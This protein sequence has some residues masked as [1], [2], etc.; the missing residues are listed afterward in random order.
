V[1]AIPD[2]FHSVTPYLPVRGAE[3]LLDFLGR[4]FGATLV[5]KFHRPDGSVMHAQVKIGDTR[6]MMAEACEEWGGPK[7]TT[8]NL[9][10]EDADATYR[11]ALDA[12]GISLMEPA[13][14][15]YGD[16]HAGV[17]DPCGNTW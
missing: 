17:S 5:H 14:Q 10:V 3:L 7:P 12:G 2:G 13:D 4:A 6:M 1:K 15:F 8:F 9:Y 11:Q 16:R